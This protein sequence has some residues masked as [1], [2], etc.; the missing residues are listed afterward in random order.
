MATRDARGRFIKGVKVDDRVWREVKKQALSLDQM[1]VKVGVIDGKGAE[2]RA[3]GGKFTLGEIAALHEFGQEGVVEER[4]F[5]R[6]TLSDQQAKIGKFTASLWGKVMTNRL[7][8]ARALELLGAM[9]AGEVKLTITQ[10]RVGGPDLAPSTIARKG[11]SKKLL[12]KGQLLGAISFEV[13][14]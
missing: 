14:A 3:A 13:V 12:D 4:S 5:L 11:S 10:D 6:K 2:R 8:P 7:A 1:H 9:V